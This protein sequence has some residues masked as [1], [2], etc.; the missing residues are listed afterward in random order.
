[1]IKNI[2]LAGKYKME[3]V[4]VDTGERRLLADWFENLILDQGLN[5]IG[6][7]GIMSKCLAGS[8][9]T[10][11]VNTNSS[12][13]SL[14]GTTTTQTSTTTGNHIETD[15]SGYG[16]CRRVYRFSPGDATGNI[17]EVGVGSSASILFSR[18]LVKD[19]DGNPTTITVL[20]NE[21]LDV[22]YELRNYWP[23]ADQTFNLTI[24][25]VVTAVV[26]RTAV[27]GGDAWKCFFNDSGAAWGGGFGSCRAYDGAIGDMTQSPSGTSD[28][29]ASRTD[30]TYSNNSLT[31]TGSTT[32]G[33]DNAN[34]SGGTIHSILWSNL[35]GIFQ[36]SF[37]PPIPKN[38]TQTLTL[39][40]GVAWA[41][42]T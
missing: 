37:T 16:W 8:G 38:N 4:N 26:L 25:G 12:L 1:M 10:P 27:N 7:T 41:R 2:G 22:T 20:S 17:S 18:S 29:S 34:F 13:Q 3:A 36:A 28:G 15:N 9:S 11:P 5:L 21:Y 33:I 19:L 6:T 42:K 40:L 35:M 39:A 23:T 14:I 30:N 31:W 24:N 32:F